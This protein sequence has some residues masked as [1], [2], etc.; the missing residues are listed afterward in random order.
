LSADLVNLVTTLTRR[1]AAAPDRP[2]FRPNSP[3]RMAE[4]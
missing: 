4:E 1:V 2:A 3:F